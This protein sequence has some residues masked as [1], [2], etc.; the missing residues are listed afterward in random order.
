MLAAASS[1]F[2]RKGFHDAQMT[3][4]ASDAELSLK[5][6]YALFDSKDDLFR[7]VLATTAER[8]QEAVQ[9]KAQAIPDPAERLLGVV[10]FRDLIVTP[11]DKLVREVMRT[12]VITAPEDLDQEALSALFM[13]HHLLMIPIVDAAGRVKGV[14]S[15]DDIVGVVQEEATEDIHKIG[16]VQT[17]DAP[18]L[19]VPLARMIRK[20]AGWLAALFLGE[21]PKLG[22][23]ES[24][25]SALP[26]SAQRSNCTSSPLRDC[27]CLSSPPAAVA[28]NSQTPGSAVVRSVATSSPARRSAAVTAAMRGKR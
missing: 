28:T 13:R 6:V 27:A 11:G 20:R 15:V 10:S 18:Y 26:W 8:M 23:R 9:S 21:P 24:A 19:Q 4:I 22:A 2:A 17:L 14:V 5:S 25:E 7:A 1:V 3:E 12:E 16:A